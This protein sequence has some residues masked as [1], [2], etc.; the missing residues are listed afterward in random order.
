MKPIK[1]LGAGCA[2]C[3]TT[4]KLIAE[5]AKAKGIEVEI[6]KV[7]DM[8]AI[9]GYVSTPGVVIDGKVVHAGGMPS[10]ATVESW[11]AR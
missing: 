3:E 5:M 2:N 7:T 6:E 11:L 9:L 4:A 8:S 10:R 1:I